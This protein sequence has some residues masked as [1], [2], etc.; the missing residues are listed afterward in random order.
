MDA[1]YD[2]PTAVTFLFAGLGLGAVVAILLEPTD[3]HPS[4]DDGRATRTT[5]GRVRRGRSVCG[6]CR[7]IEGFRCLAE[8]SV[9]S[10]NVPEESA[11]RGGPLVKMSESIVVRGAR[12]HNLKNIDFAIP[13]NSLTVVT[14]VSGSGKSSLAF[15]TI[16]AEGQRRYVESLSAYARQFLER[17]EKPDADV[18][19]GIAPAVAIRQKNTT[20]NPRS[21]VATATEIYDY[22]RLLFRAGRAHVLSEVRPGGEEGHGRRSRR[23]H[24]G[25]GRRNPFAGAV[26]FTVSTPRQ[27]NALKRKSAHERKR[28]EDCSQASVRSC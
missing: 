3:T 10:A 5:P 23:L 1:R 27:P 24:H 14:G 16:Y 17:I 2:V 28:T 21:T 11:G 13:H 18:I 7:I 22:L 9:G 12:V 20:R 4:M 6:A 8:A 19:D 15:D 26:P 25:N